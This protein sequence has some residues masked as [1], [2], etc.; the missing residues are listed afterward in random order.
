MKTRTMIAFVCA[1]SAGNTG[2]SEADKSY[3]NESKAQIAYLDRRIEGKVIGD[4]YRPPQFESDLLANRNKERYTFVVEAEDT[5]GR[6]GETRTVVYVVEGPDA[7]T[8][9]AIINKGDVVKIHTPYL[10]EKCTAT[11]KP[12][13]IEEVNGKRLPNY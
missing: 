10:Y 8:L 1:L 9:D 2:C 13:D 12:M 5:F 11:I 7:A 6:P 3:K 4:N